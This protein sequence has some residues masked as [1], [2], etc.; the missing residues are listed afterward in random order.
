MWI[1]T[2][3]SGNNHSVFQMINIILDDF[4][5]ETKQIPDSFFK[6]LHNLLAWGTFSL[7]TIAV[8]VMV[9]S[10]ILFVFGN[11]WIEIA[12]VKK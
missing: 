1:L 5:V 2:K 4:L 12:W 7:I 11:S 6:R 10:Q 8:I 9:A 3:Q